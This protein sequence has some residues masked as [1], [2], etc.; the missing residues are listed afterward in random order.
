MSFGST[1]PTPGSQAVLQLQWD[2]RQNKDVACQLVNSWIAGTDGTVLDEEERRMI[3][4]T[5]R[6]GTSEVTRKVESLLRVDLVHFEQICNQLLSLLIS[7]EQAILKKKRYDKEGLRTGNGEAQ[8]SPREFMILF[9]I[10]YYRAQAGLTILPIS[11]SDSA[12]PTNIYL[13]TEI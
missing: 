13:A 2:C 12:Q 4:K 9:Q 1:G 11:T 6:M 3:A 8:L 10:T 5:L 7:W